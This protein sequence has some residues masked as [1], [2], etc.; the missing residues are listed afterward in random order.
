M[1]RPA[2]ARSGS[3]TD[4]DLVRPSRLTRLSYASLALA[5]VQAV[6][7]AVVRI[8]GSGMGCG[9]HWP[10][11]HGYWFPPLDRL[12]LIIEVTHRYVAAALTL[13]VLALL[14]T[15]WSARRSPGVG[16]P[17]GVLGPTF[18]A[19]LLVVAAAL[20]GAVTVKLD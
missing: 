14:I 8:T 16:G 1:G 10:R 18:A 3:T 5:Y 9:D 6:L 19:A 11:C 12:D 20:L 7:G 15:A 4:S 2:R 13:A 17:G